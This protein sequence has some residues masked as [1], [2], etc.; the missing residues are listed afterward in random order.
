VRG[1]QHGATLAAV[2][3]TADPCQVTGG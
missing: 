3:P 2:T 1:I